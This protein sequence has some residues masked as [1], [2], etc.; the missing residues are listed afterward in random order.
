MMMEKPAKS[1]Y[2]LI[3]R[4]IGSIETGDKPSMAGPA[5]SGGG[6]SATSIYLLARIRR[7][8][9]PT[10]FGRGHAG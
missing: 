4:Q 8:L 5:P 10:N 2:Y 6:P 7:L 3:A 9:G 1:Q